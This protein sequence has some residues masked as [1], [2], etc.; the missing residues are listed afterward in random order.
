M[1][2]YVRHKYFGVSR[3]FDFPQLSGVFKKNQKPNINVP[4]I[5]CV[6]KMIA[7]NMRLFNSG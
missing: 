7:W 3:D 6:T 4:L 2:A 5:K 1:M